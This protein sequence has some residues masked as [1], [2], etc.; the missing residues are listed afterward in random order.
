MALLYGKLHP[1]LTG[2]KELPERTNLDNLRPHK[3]QNY[4]SHAQPGVD[5]KQ[6]VE[7][8]PPPAEG[9]MALTQKDP[10]HLKGPRLT[11]GKRSCVEK[12]QQQTCQGHSLM[13]RWKRKL[14]KSGA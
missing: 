7:A 10:R 14:R 1:A 9:E 6:S 2:R 8:D 5:M 13:A 12:K 11:S 3:T 4:Q